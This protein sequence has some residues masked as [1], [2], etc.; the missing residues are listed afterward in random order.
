MHHEMAIEMAQMAVTQAEHGKI[1]STAQKIIKAQTQEI[2]RMKKIANRLGVTPVTAGA[3]MQMMD[4]LET[5]G[6]T[7][8]QAGMD[9]EW[10]LLDGAKPFDREFIDMMV[11]HHQARS[12]WPGSS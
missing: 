12:A 11:P 7:M 5:L 9:M 10:T 3:H 4:G 1:K 6:L 2:G 8:K